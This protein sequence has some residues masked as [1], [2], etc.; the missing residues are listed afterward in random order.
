MA[1]SRGKNRA[2]IAVAHSL[3]VTVYS[4]T[5]ASQPYRDLGLDYFDRLNK[6]QLEKSLVSRLEKLGHKVTLEPK[7]AAA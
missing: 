1:R 5:T 4:F 7:T 3:L 6:G 2:L